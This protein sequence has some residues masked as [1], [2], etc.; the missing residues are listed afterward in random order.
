MTGNE[1]V[2]LRGH[3]LSYLSCFSLNKY[4]MESKQMKT[5]V[6]VGVVTSFLPS[7]NGPSVGGR[8]GPLCVTHPTTSR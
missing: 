2:S 6:M 1:N 8:K 7:S 5:T 4:C 3:N